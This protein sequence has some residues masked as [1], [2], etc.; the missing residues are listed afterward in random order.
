MAIYVSSSIGNDSHNGLAPEFDGVN[1][2]KKST[3]SSVL[4]A[5]FVDA[6]GPEIFF[7]RGDTFGIHTVPSN[8]LVY[9]AYGDTSLPMP[10]FRGAITITGLQPYAEGA[11]QTFSATTVSVTHVFANDVRLTAGSSP[12]TLENKQFIYTGGIFYIR[13]DDGNPNT[14]GVLIEGSRETQCINL[15]SKSNITFKNLKVTKAA[16]Y[17]FRFTTGTGIKIT[18]CEIKQVPTGIQIDTTSAVVERSKISDVNTGINVQN[19]TSTYKIRYNLLTQSNSASLIT[20]ASSSSGSITNNVIAGAASGCISHSGTG[21]TVIKNNIIFGSGINSAT[22]A[23]LINSGAATVENNLILPCGTAPKTRFLSGVNPTTK[24]IYNDPK[25]VKHRRDAIVTVMMDDNTHKDWVQVADLV[26]SVVGANAYFAVK[27][28]PTSLQTDKAILQERINQ[29]HRLGSH[30]R[31]HCML[32]VSAAMTVQYTGAATTATITKSGNTVTTTIDG[33]TDLTID[34]ADYNRMRGVGD[35]VAY[36]NSQANYSASYEFGQDENNATMLADVTGENILSALTLNFDVDRWHTHLLEGSIADLAA[37]FT[38][39][40]GV[41]PYQCKTIAYPNGNRNQDVIN[42]CQAAGFTGARVVGGTGDRSKI[43]ELSAA[44]SEVYGNATF[45]GFENSVASTGVAFTNSGVTFTSVN[46]FYFS[47]SGV[48]N[49]SA[50]I[51]AANNNELNFELGDWVVSIRIKPATLGTQTLYFNGSDAS[52]FIKIFLDSTGKLN[53]QIRKNGSDALLLTTSNAITLNAWNTVKVQNYNN[54]F[55]LKLNGSG[56]AFNSTVKPDKYTGVHYVGCGYDFGASSTTDFYNG[57]MDNFLSAVGT[58]YKTMGMLTYL[59]YI[60]GYFAM[61]AHG[62]PEIPIDVWDVVLNVFKDYSGELRVLTLDDAV[63]YIK[64][65][66][67]LQADGQ[68][69]LTEFEDVTDYRIASDSPCK[70]AGDPTVYTGEPNLYTLDGVQ[71][72]DETGTVVGPVHIGACS[73]VAPAGPTITTHPSDSTVTE[74]QTA[75][76]TVEATTESGPL[77]Y[78]WY[79]SGTAV[80]GATSATYSFVTSLVD[81]GATI[82]CAV[83]DAN[84]TT[85]SNTATLTVGALL[86]ITSQP[87]DQTVIE[88]QAAQFAVVAVGTGTLH[89]Q[90]Y[91]NGA[92]VGTDSDTYTVTPTSAD[93]GHAVYCVVSDD[94]GFIQSTPVTLTVE[95]ALAIIT[96]PQAQTAVATHVATFTVEAVGEGQLSYQWFKGGEEVGAGGNTYTFVAA[97]ADNG[98]Q[99]YCQVTDKNGN[100]NSNAAILTVEAQV[101]TS[102]QV[103]PPAARVALGGT[104]QFTVAGV[105]QVGGAMTITGTVDWSASGGGTISAQGLFTAGEVEGEFTVSATVSELADTAMVIVVTKTSRKR[106]SHKY[107]YSY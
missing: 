62:E 99:I 66:G 45:V 69:V 98:A 31:E 43:Y 93:S 97:D 91:K 46:P 58:Y 56:P 79:K 59:S 85:D 16:S 11:G 49:G 57:N 51:Y 77:S 42:K 37:I 23:I 7:R 55:I 65:S 67:T 105:D 1:G 81:T 26:K 73:A 84:G 17:G 6:N 96:H 68:T 101:L 19:A 20:V 38:E 89:Y 71:I 44:S 64:Q 2:P 104:R 48:F 4:S 39:A 33:V 47:A 94:N 75:S 88:G 63:E 5:A 72:T 3:S 82:Y 74:G 21:S 10:V 8:N 32:A 80:E 50:Y 87:T 100:L 29:G 15:S 41:T 102:I 106:I 18:N 103:N 14:L 27:T 22:A 83:T 9:D 24:N 52:N 95:T 76:F 36:I 54:K 92:Q 25:F 53:L 107:G 34:L 78:Q 28:T 12:T 35:L 90:W 13:W 40:D 30:C 70:E 60:G 86:A 61:F